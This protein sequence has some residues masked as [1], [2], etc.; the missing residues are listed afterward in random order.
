MTLL[1]VVLFLPLLGFLLL[2]F[3]PKGSDRLPRVM[4]LGISLV[5]FVI[6]LGLTGPFM[7][8]GR[9]HV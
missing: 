2:V 1:D 4:A 9:A 5:V 6:S 3:T 7:E 8:I